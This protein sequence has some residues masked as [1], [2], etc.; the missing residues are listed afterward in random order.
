MLFATSVP[1]FV[2]LINFIL[3]FFS[4]T[5]NPSF[6]RVWRIFTAWLYVQSTSFA[7]MLPYLALDSFFRATSISAGFLRKN[8]SKL[9]FILIIYLVL[10]IFQSVYCF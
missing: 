4:K 10:Y 9:S 6:S 7:R 1:F 3:P 8:T 2:S 5:T